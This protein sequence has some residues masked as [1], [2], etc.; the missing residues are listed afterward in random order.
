M[1]IIIFAILMFFI[2]LLC[3]L[4]ILEKL[5]YSNIG[6]INTI[7]GLLT[8]ISIIVTQLLATF[9]LLCSL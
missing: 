1:I 7:S 6:D 5:G 8:Y 3:E 4:L 2:L 9:I